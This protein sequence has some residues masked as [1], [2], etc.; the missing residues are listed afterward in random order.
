LHLVRGASLSLTIS[1]LHDD[2]TPVDTSGAVFVGQVR[3]HGNDRSPLIVDLSLFASLNDAGVITINLPAMAT[4]H[5]PAGLWYWDAWV[6][7][8]Q[9]RATQIIQGRFQISER[10]TNDPSAF[11]P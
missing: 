11:T 3:E 2:E 9:N 7:W 4:A 6:R 8:D 10:I 1:Y 5:L